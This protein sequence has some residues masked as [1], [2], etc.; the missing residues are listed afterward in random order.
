MPAARDV[1]LTPN[2]ETNRAS[3]IDSLNSAGRQ[4]HTLTL[5][6]LGGS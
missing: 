4:H 3:P 2:S 5:F 6:R 1:G